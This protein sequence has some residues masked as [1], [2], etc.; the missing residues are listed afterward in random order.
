MS[1]ADGGPAF[2]SAEVWESQML[3]RKGIDGMSLR[4][5][6]AGQALVGLLA[7]PHTNSTDLPMKDKSRICY[8][9]ADALLTAREAA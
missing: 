5:Y 7:R 1:R 4:D 2:P 9:Y 6:L 3:R 8:A